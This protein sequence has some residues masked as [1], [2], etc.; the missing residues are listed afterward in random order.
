MKDIEQN[1]R[2]ELIIMDNTLTFI[3]AS[4]KAETTSVLHSG[5]YSKE[6]SSMLLASGL[7]V[8][9][10]MYA[11]FI[12]ST[13]IRSAILILFFIVFFYGSRTYVFYDKKM[14]V[15]FDNN[16]GVVRI[17]RPGFIFRKT[18]TI[19]VSTVS[20]VEMG[21]RKFTPDNPDGVAFVEKISAQHGSFIPGL[22]E[23]EEF[24]TLSLML[25]DG[26]DRLIFA[27]HIDDEPEIPLGKIRSHLG[28]K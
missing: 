6:F 11:D 1:S 16:D 28:M 15:T 9:V 2:Y 17:K 25:T 10:Y 3:T 18:E 19:P 5:V 20:S 4:F 12:E 26:T 22:G 7:C 14:E 27:G 13:V 24:V 8:L 23:E 21:S